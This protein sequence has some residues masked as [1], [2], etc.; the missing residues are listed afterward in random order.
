MELVL[1]PF[2]E[3]ETEAQGDRGTLPRL[4]NTWVETAQVSYPPK[5]NPVSRTPASPGST[6][7]LS[8]AAPPPISL[9][10]DLFYEPEARQLLC[11]HGNKPRTDI[12]VAHSG[13]DDFCC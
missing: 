5:D 3:K 7:L 13:V 10:Y 2:L 9:L 12:L 8:P 11:C 1:F 4:L 6:P